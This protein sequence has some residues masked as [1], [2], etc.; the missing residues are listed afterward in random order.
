M[1]PIKLPSSSQLEAEVCPPGS[2]EQEEVIA[3]PPLAP[4]IDG[5]VVHGK[6][7]EDIIDGQNVYFSLCGMS[8]AS[9]EQRKNHIYHHSEIRIYVLCGFGPTRYLV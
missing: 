3:A 9:K 1:K 6:G 4:D 2:V 7:R 8:C 5:P